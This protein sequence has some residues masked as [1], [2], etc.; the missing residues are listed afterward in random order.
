MSIDHLSTLILEYRYW[1]LIPLTLIEGPIVAFIAG[2]LASLHYFNIYW[3][4]VLFFCRDVGLDSLY[5]L[6]GYYGGNTSFVKR[7]LAKIGINDNELARIRLVWESHPGKTMLIG[8]LSYGIA[9]AFIVAAGTVKMR[10]ATFFKYG[11]LVAVAQYGTLLFL[12]YF[13]GATFGGSLSG[14]LEN[15][16][17]ILAGLAIV[18]SGYYILTWHMRKKFLKHSV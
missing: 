2:T 5:Y 8:K 16:Q 11:A 12:G 9:Q 7:M 6:A 14:I 15:I 3:L 17:Y 13:F 10:F 4:A 18:I 1:I